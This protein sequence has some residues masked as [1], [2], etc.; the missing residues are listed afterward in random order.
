MKN[1]FFTLFTLFSFANT[2]WCTVW[3]V[4]P[5]RTYTVPSAVSGL[6]SDGDTVQIDAGTYN[7]CTEWNKSNLLLQGV[8]NGYAH[9]VSAV[10]GD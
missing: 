6:V 5:T 9:C 4:G 2:A 7:D 1:K 3:Q 8:G 10:C